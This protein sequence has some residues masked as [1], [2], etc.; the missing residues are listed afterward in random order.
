MK[1]YLVTYYEIHPIHEIPISA[2]DYADARRIAIAL[3]PFV[4]EYF[5]IKEIGKNEIV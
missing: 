2:K 3:A 5:E 1:K 4:Y